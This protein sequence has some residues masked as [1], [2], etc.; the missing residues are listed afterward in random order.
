MVDVVDVVVPL[1][2]VEDRP[3]VLALE[4]VGVVG[5][6]LEHQM[7]VAPRR[8]R[9]PHGQRDLL[10][11]MR[12]AVVDDPVHGIEAQP[13]E[14]VFLEPVQHVVDRD[15]AHRAL[16]IV[17]RG[18]PGRVLLRIE[19]VGRVKAE[20]VPLGPE[21]VVD[22][23]EERHQ[24][25]AVDLVDQPL[26]LVGAAVAGIRR[27]RQHAVVAPVARARKI[28][29]RHQ[30]DRG[31]AE[32][33][34]MVE[35]AAQAI[36]GALLAERADM[37]LVQHRL[38][39]RPAA[40]V[41]VLPLVAAADRPPGSARARRRAGSARSGRAPPGRRRA[42]RSSG[43]RPARRRWSSSNQPSACAAIGM[44]SS[45]PASSSDT[46]RCP[47]AQRRKRTPPSCRAAPNG[48]AW[49][50]V[51][52][53]RAL[54]QAAWQTNRISE[55]PGTWK[56]SADGVHGGIVGHVRIG[57]VETAPPADAAG[58]PGQ[59]ERHHVV[60]GVHHDQQDVVVG[61][62]AI[63]RAIVAGLA[64]QHQP[65]ALGERV[66]PFLQASSRRPWAISR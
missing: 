38:V 18:P 20:I 24:A 52:L 44:A 19:V 34:Q 53:M 5:V 2:I 12:L 41:R 36:V 25:A 60:V 35:L 62:L 14:A 66:V 45:R 65:E 51:A 27:E 33:G 23:V 56:T 48:M 13:V 8:D 31:H 15:V 47:G 61:R 55:R 10:Q 26:E 59:L 54:P 11:N 9:L 49:L 43:C 64:V 46:W 32:P 7:D 1:R 50:K 6:V 4:Q 21:V 3:A 57:R 63:G 58:D 40:P 16:S 22:H 29:K 39:P 28:G 42:G 17:D 30:L 37:Q